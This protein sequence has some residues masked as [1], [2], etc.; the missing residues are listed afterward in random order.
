[1][2]KKI[3]ASKIGPICYRIH[4]LNQSISLFGSDM[5]RFIE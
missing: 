2:A 3:K 5:P 1:M 4:K